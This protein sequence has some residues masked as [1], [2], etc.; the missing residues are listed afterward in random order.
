MTHVAEEKRNQLD[1]I[2]MQQL[3]TEDERQEFLESNWDH[4][5]TELSEEEPLTVGS[6]ITTILT[7]IQQLFTIVQECRIDLEEQ[8]RS[9]K[10][11][12]ARMIDRNITSCQESVDQ[13]EGGD[14]SIGKSSSRKLYQNHL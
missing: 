9:N 3:P 4:S 8:I 6:I 5:I 11:D 1:K 12:T 13:V 2:I 7:Q 10:D 14:T